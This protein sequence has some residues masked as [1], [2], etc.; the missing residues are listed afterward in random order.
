M[1]PQEHGAAE[2]HPADRG[3]VS[4]L[5]PAVARIH[6]AEAARLLRD[7]DLAPGQELVLMQLWHHEPRSQ[8][9]LTRELA[10][11]PPTMA[12]TLARLEAA[13]MVTRER[14]A[15]DR[16]QVLVALTAKGRALEDQ[17]GAAWA[18]LE[19]RTVEALSDAEQQELARLLSR[20]RD[21][22]DEDRRPS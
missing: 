10:V 21:G 17:V 3:P 1:D 7:L 8:A 14:S 22:L 9:E 13:G 6:R 15:E 16:R 12:K 18:E 19:R 4:A 2:A 20:V 11:E 5:I